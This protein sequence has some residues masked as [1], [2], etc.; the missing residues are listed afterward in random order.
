LQLQWQGVSFWWV[1]HA[2]TAG[3]AS[4]RHQRR[5]G[6]EEDKWPTA[7]GRLP[8]PPRVQWRGILPCHIGMHPV[9]GG[10]RL[11][12]QRASSLQDEINACSEWWRQQCRL[13]TRCHGIH[14]NDIWVLWGQGVRAC[15]VVD[16]RNEDGG[17]TAKC[18][19]VLGCNQHVCHSK[20]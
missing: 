5:Q 10:A 17:N 2:T 15:P 8:T 13:Q 6:R 19:D 11:A 14:N 18:S 12:G 1:R 7:Q 3:A 4:P 9:T 20:R 16:G